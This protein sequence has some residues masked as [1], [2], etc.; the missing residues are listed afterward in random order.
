MKKWFAT[1]LVIWWI[2]IFT[3]CPS[4]AETL[5]AP[6]LTNNPHL[7][8]IVTNERPLLTFYNA[9]GGIGQKIYIIQV[10]KSPSFDSPSLVEYNNVPET[11]KIITSKCH[12]KS[13]STSKNNQFKNIE[14]K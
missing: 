10:D 12:C 5:T 14:V 4:T 3:I 13:K 8:V 1:C 9:S 7:D 6:S 11:N 2:G